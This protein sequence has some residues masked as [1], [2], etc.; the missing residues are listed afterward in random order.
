M[1]V[2]VVG[3]HVTPANEQRSLWATLLKKIQFSVV[4]GQRFQYLYLAKGCFVMCQ[5]GV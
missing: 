4:R 2:I 1:S 5:L 3:E